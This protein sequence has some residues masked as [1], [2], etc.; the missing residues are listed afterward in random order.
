MLKQSERALVWV[1]AALTFAAMAL[2]TGLFTL[3]EQVPMTTDMNPGLYSQLAYSFPPQAMFSTNYWLGQMVMPQD[4]QPM[5]LFARLPAWLFFS[6]YYPLMGALSVLACYAFVRELRFRRGVAVLCGLIYG[7]QGDQFSTLLAGHFSTATVW[8]LFA[9]AGWLAVRCARTRSWLDSAWCG[10]CTGMMVSILPDRGALCSMVIGGLYLVA[11]WR[12]RQERSE[13]FK[14]FLRLILVVAVAV[15]V[16]APGVLSTLA[17]ATDKAGPA[18]VETKAQKYQWATQWSYTPEDICNYVI[19]GFFGWRNGSESGPYWGRIGQSAQENDPG[20]GR[21]FCLAIFTLGTAGFLLAAVGATLTFPSRKMA[22]WLNAEQLSYARFA[23][24]AAILG[25][26]LSL[27]KYGPLYSLFYQLPYMDTWRNPLKFLAPVSLVLVLLAACGAEFLSRLVECGAEQGRSKKNVEKNLRYLLWAVGIAWVLSFPARLP[28]TVRL[29]TLQYNSQEIES[30]LSTLRSS[31]FFAG[32]IIAGLWA[33]WRLLRRPEAERK[34]EFINPLIQKSWEAMV[35]PENLGRTWL[36]LLGTLVI[37]QMFWVQ[38]HY[39]ELYNFRAYYAVSPLVAKLQPKDDVWRVSVETSDPILHQ[40]LST[41][42]PYH[43]IQC[44]DIPAASRIADDYSQFFKTLQDNRVRLQ[45]LA[46]VRYWVCSMSSLSAIQEDPGFKP[47]I[48]QI[49]YYTVDP[50]YS[51]GGPTHAV[52]ELKDYLF[53]VSLVPRIEIQRDDEALQKRLADPAW[54]PHETVLV[55]QADKRSATL[56]AT[57]AP[58]DAVKKLIPSTRLLRY[59]DR[60]IEVAVESPVPATLLISDRFDKG[61]KAKINDKPATLFPADFILR[62]LAIPAG[63]SKVVLTYEIPMM[64]YY[65]Q[66]AVLALIVA[67]TGGAWLQCQR[68]KDGSL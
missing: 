61:W 50:R 7:W 58:S 29:L 66:L 38:S 51:N 33:S 46:G 5:S 3:G 62:G 13:A 57:E 2:L 48:K 42:F 12:G 36:A 56:P 25:W 55:H 19:P 39:S 59:D 31:L 30:I 34:Q 43:G 20:T 54:N 6:G 60:R 45:Q 63:S 23:L 47:L 9:M 27:G 24:A 52:V 11:L 53:K 37:L 41:L 35:L 44:L 64:P 16:A 26:L 65:V 68:G 14:H 32:L 4:L 67:W 10:V 22:T 28:I 17:W 21:N 15:A 8:F 18:G 49:S 40:S 1:A